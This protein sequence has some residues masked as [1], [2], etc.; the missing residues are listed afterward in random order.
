MF[1][2][3][4]PSASRS[5]RGVTVTARSPAGNALRRLATMSLNDVTI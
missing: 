2:S 1:D 3:A 4:W 5:L